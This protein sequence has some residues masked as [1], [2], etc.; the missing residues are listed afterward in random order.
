MSCV[1]VYSDDASHRTLVPDRPARATFCSRGQG[2]WV[3]STTS[4]VSP[5]SGRHRWYGP[6]YP[7]PDDHEGGAQTPRRRFRWRALPVAI[8]QRAWITP[9]HQ[10][11]RWS[12]DPRR[13]PA[14]LLPVQRR[15]RAGMHPATGSDID[16]V[17]GDSPAQVSPQHVASGGSSQRP[18]LVPPSCRRRPVCTVRCSR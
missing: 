7:V 8:L 9:T 3:V 11:P 4:R 6:A 5:A 14:R 18:F 10:S 15:S 1:I 16:R 2:S 12:Q 13:S 17:P